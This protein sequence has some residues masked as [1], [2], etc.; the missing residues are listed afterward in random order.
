MS[1]RYQSLRRD[2]LNS[3]PLTSSVS[4]SLLMRNP[5]LFVSLHWPTEAAFLQTLAADPQ[6]ASVPVEHFEPVASPVTKHKQVSTQGIHPQPISRYPEKAVKTFA[7][8][9]RSS[10]QVHPSG[11][12]QTDH[13][14]A[15]TTVQ[16]FDLLQYLKQ[17]QQIFRFKSRH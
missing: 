8:V 11:Q 9:G 2:W 3:I 5:A 12:S 6:P 10:R 4:S 13:N 7:H 1:F 16:S 14:F 15:Q 17:P